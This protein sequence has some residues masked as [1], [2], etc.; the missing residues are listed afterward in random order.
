MPKKTFML[1]LFSSAILVYLGFSS[2]RPFKSRPAKNDAEAM[3][4]PKLPD[5]Y[6]KVL[7]QQGRFYIT[8]DNRQWR[9]SFGDGPGAR[10]RGWPSK[11]GLYTLSSCLRVELDF[12]G[13]DHFEEADRP[14][15]ST[16]AEAD[17]EAH[18]K[19]M[20]QL[21][22]TW[23]PSPDDETMWWFL[24]PEHS[25]D[26]DKPVNY[27]GW[28]A[29]GGVWVLNTTIIGASEMGAGRIHIATTMD[30]R[31]KIME[32]LGA[33]YYAKPEDCPLLDLSDEVVPGT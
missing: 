5:S 18:C 17:E 20:R 19:R 22:A 24:N 7:E 15:N 8:G 31:C 3:A 26:L 21:G 1:L 10:V 16:S 6:D 30:E 11:G 27:S 12:L 33:V 9:V 28:P 13:L 25:W 32:K 14:Q 29:Q 23:W 4:T 2:L